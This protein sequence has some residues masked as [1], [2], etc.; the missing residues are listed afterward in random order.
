MGKSLGVVCNLYNEANALPGWLETHTAFFD[1][2]RV[3]HSGPGGAKSD[4]GT[5]EILE[6]WKI[7]IV[8]GSIDEGFGV[9][10]TAAIR[11]SPCDYVMIL[12]ADERFHPLNQ[13]MTCSGES[14]PFDEVGQILYD[15]DRKIDFTACPSNF[16]NLRKLGAKLNV[17]FGEVYNQ[18]AW[19]RSIIDANDYDAIKCVR[20]HWHDFTR[21]KPTQNWHTEPDYQQR[22]VRNKDS[23]HFSTDTRMHESLLGAENV[24]QPNFTHGPFFDHYHLHFKVMEMDQRRHDVAI[25]DKLHRG[26]NPPSREDHE[27]LAKISDQR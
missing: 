1:D 10:R 18:G 25:Y 6:R 3:Y 5:I 8:Y 19:L 21:T 15:Y 22:L 24:Y 13:V 20:R 26:E 11:S 23:V 27:Q 2:V 16:E 12:D 4:D 17:S 14:T 9:V 7:P